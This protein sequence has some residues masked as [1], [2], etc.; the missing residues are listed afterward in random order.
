MLM[1]NIKIPTELFEMMAGYI[2]DHYDMEDMSRYH[3]IETGIR[4]KYEAMQRHEYYTISKPDVSED[5]R[6]WARKEYLDAAGIHKDFH[7]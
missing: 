6:E 5:I 4:R 7:W 3:K 1:K 2:H